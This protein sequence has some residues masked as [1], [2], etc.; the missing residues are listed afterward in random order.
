M[1]AGRRWT[2]RRWPRPDD[3]GEEPDYRFTLANE[4]TFLAWIRTSLA[5]LAAAVAVVQLLP[6]FRPSAVRHVLGGLL[7]AVGL[8]ISATTYW[9]WQATQRAIR[10]GRPLPRPF[11]APILTVT[12]SVVGVVVLVTVFVR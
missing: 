10:T 7:A 12:L 8:V 6:S 9:R 2:R 1:A 5:L 3:E 11:V 4:R